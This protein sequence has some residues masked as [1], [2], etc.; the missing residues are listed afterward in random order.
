M[1]KLLN[2]SDD[3]WNK[4]QNILIYKK[5]LEKLNNA[6]NQSID[7]NKLLQTCK[8]WGWLV[9]SIDELDDILRAHGDLAEKIVCTELLYY[10]DTHKTEV[11]YNGYLFKWNKI[12]YKDRLVNLGILLGNN[13]PDENIILPTNRDALT[14]LQGNSSTND[15]G[16]DMPWWYDDMMIWVWTEQKYPLVG[17]RV[18]YVVCWLLHFKK[19]W[20]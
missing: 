13:N 18:T 11:I 15:E 16:D 6:N 9:K 4:Q 2:Q 14:I 12:S 3:D 5:I 7:T 8:S 1:F 20:Q 19:W 10:R 17:R